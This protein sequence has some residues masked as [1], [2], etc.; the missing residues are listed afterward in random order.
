MESGMP[1]FRDQNT[2]MKPSFS[3]GGGGFGGRGG[4]D[5]RGGGQGGGRGGGF[6]DE[7]VDVAKVE[8]SNLGATGDEVVAGETREET[9]Q[10]RM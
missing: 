10:G 4:F 2:V 3:P 6:R 7:E 8:A 5:D 1:E 9:S